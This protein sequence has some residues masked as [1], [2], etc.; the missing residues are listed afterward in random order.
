LDINSQLQD[1]I[2]KK[3]LF[4]DTGFEYGDD[5]SFLEHG[6]VDSTGVLDLVLFVEETY[7]LTVDDDE[8]TRENFDS[9]NKLVGFIQQ[10][11]ALAQQ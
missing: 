9:I 8:I 2:A 7:G 3:L 1:F 4:S 6:I 10:K 11:L 5:D